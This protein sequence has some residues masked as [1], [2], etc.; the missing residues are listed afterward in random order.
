VEKI[1]IKKFSEYWTILI[2]IPLGIFIN[3]LTN[4]LPLWALISL[5]LVSAILIV[6]LAIS[7]KITNYFDEK[8]QKKKMQQAKKLVDE[9][10]NLEKWNNDISDLLAN[11]AW[12]LI[13]LFFR[14]SFYTVSVVLMSVLFLSKNLG[15]SSANF[16]PLFTI[17]IYGFVI[18][19]NSEHKQL[20][21]IY[22]LCKFDEYKEKTKQK[23]KQLNGANLEIATNELIDNN[24]K[25]I[26]EN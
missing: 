26:K 15:N 24:D 13:V 8:N 17:L 20:K 2:A 22:N 23:I 11:I 16:L 4:Y 10:E 6:F 3:L 9:L 12:D 1:M 14:G 25:F 5:I 19:F 7:E 18:L 21:Y